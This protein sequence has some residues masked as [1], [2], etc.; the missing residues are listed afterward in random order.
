MY[1]YVLYTNGASTMVVHVRK[2]RIFQKSKNGLFGRNLQRS[3]VNTAQA[4]SN[5]SKAC[6]SREECNGCARL[7]IRL[8]EKMHAHGCFCVGSLLGK[9]GILSFDLRLAANP[10]DLSAPR[11]PTRSAKRT[12]VLG[13]TLPLLR[14]VRT[15]MDDVGTYSGA[16]KGH[17]SIDES[18]CQP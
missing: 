6:I 13:C 5:A 12:S 7:L 17:R 10:F 16:C 4:N 11:C 3:A 2:I 9:H 14:R 18:R 1:K 8:R 15:T